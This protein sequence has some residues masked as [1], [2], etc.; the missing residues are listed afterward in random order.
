L[1]GGSESGRKLMLEDRYFLT[2]DLDFA[3]VEPKSVLHDID[4]YEGPTLLQNWTMIRP[5]ITA[6]TLDVIK[7]M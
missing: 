4:F 2:T 1:V 6:L 5:I 3:S 7:N